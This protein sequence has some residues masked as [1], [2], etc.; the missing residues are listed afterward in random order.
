MPF[1]IIAE[2]RGGGDLERTLAGPGRVKLLS[3]V[4]FI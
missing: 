2:A 3:T 4:L 1:G